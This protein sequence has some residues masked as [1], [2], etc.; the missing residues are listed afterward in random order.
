M[1]PWESWPARLALT[2]PT[3]TAVA[4]ASDA[5]AAFNSAVPMRVRRSAWTIGMGFPRNRARGTRVLLAQDPGKVGTGFPKRSCAVNTSS[6]TGEGR[7]SPQTGQTATVAA[8]PAHGDVHRNGTGA[9]RLL[10][11]R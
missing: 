4:S 7:A 8:P 9:A 3:A 5:P 6:Q 1:M 11:F 10:F 2:Q